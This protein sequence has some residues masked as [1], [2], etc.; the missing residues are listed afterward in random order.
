MADA[1]DAGR[2]AFGAVLPP[3]QAESPSGGCCN[4][5]NVP[6]HLGVPLTCCCHLFTHAHRGTHTCTQARTHVYCTHAHRLV[7]TRLSRL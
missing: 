2:R 1:G 4:E 7:H 5:L 6:Y 3:G